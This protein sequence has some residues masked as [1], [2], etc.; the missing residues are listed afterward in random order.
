[1]WKRATVANQLKHVKI[2]LLHVWGSQELHSSLRIFLLCYA[3]DDD[4]FCS[5]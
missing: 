1:M 2:Q 4:Q 3:L 5:N